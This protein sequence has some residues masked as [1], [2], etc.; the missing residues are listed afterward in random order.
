VVPLVAGTHTFESRLT[1]SDGNGTI[2]AWYN[3]MTAIYSPFGGTEGSALNFT[4]DV[5]HSPLR[6][7]QE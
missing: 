1:R 4:G 7:P 2:Y 6:L 5:P 3:A